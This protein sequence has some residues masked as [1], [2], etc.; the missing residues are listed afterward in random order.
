MNGFQWR[1]VEKAHENREVLDEW[2]TGFVDDLLSRGSKYELT[3]EQNRK[4]NEISNKLFSRRG[5]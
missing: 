5:K 1:I 3:G 2:E 4:L